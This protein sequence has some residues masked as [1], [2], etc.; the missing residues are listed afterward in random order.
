MKPRE[1]VLKAINH[2]VPDRVPLDFGGTAVTGMAATVVWKLRRALGLDAENVPVKLAEPYWMLGE[3][4]DDLRQVL[5]IDTVPLGSRMNTFGFQNKDWKP[6]R[7]F[8]GTPVLVPGLFNTEADESGNILQYPQGDRTV[9]PSARMPKGGFYFDPIYRQPPIDENA[10]DPKDNIEEFSLLGELTLENLRRQAEHLHGD[11]D[12]AVVGG[13]AGTAFG[14]LT[15]IA[16]IPLKHP[17]GI[18]SLEEWFTSLVLRKGYV[19]EVFERECEIA[20]RNLE[21]LRQAVQ[22]NMDI[23]A[24]TGTDFGSQ[25]GPLISPATYRELYKPFYKRV[26]DWIHSHTKW[27]T[28]MHSCGA[29]EPFIDDFI[30]AGFDI[31]NPVQCLAAGM[32]PGNLKKKYGDRITFWGGGVNTQRTLPFGTAEEVRREVRER[33]E[34]FSHGGGFVFSGIHNVLA[35]SPVENVLAMLETVRG[36]P[37]SS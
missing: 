3:I 30:D 6:W 34:T 8:D 5:G 28:F 26:N 17:K 21:L 2:E 13:C 16:G 37:F 18:R 10:L 11:T 1:R 29:V 12:Y 32:E 35:E 33:I 25:R 4:G 24:I 7:L 23:A 31:L 15:G 27:K 22:D 19:Y 14:S 36:V 20:M 9:P